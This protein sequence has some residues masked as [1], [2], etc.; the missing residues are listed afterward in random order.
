MASSR[1]VV[2]VGLVSENP[3]QNEFTRWDL[4]VIV[5]VAEIIRK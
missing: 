4:V 1:K 3:T 2:L 5:I